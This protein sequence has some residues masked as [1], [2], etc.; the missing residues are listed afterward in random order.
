MNEIEETSSVLSFAS[1]IYWFKLRNSERLNDNLLKD[2]ETWRSVSQGI[3]RSNRNG[4]HSERDL[5]N[6]PEVS[7][8]SLCE[9]IQQ[10]VLAVTLKS[11]PSLDVNGSEIFY[12]GWVNINPTNAFNSPHRHSGCVWSG[13][14]YAKIPE[15]TNKYSGAIEFIDPRS[16]DAAHRLKESEL[17]L[18]KLTFRPQAGDLVVFPSYLLH[19]VAPNQESDERVSIAF[20]VRIKKKT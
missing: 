11:A 2:S 17:F 19:W 9:A 7:F 16:I 6:R 3:D 1:P 4:W 14:Y 5:F 12:D 18:D 13:T 15:S 10:C 20:N 8:K